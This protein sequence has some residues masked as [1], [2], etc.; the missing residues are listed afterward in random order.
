L[1]I[2]T[3]LLIGFCAGGCFIR[4][5]HRRPRN[6]K[7]ILATGLIV[8]AAIYVAFALRSL[9]VSWWLMVE[10][11]GVG[12][13]GGMALLGVKH[14]VLWLASAWA[15]HPVWDIAIHYHGPGASF[16][17]DWY[18][19][20]CVSFDLLVAAYIAHTEIRVLNAAKPRT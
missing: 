10:L 16:A 12:I 9:N 8:A 5:A 11:I 7:L 4:Y 6:V 18:A 15:L 20:A 3:W 19:I 1:Y 14:S 17:P 13:Y 2:E